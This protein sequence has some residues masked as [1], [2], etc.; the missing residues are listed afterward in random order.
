MASEDPPRASTADSGRCPICRAPTEK[1]YRP[2]CSGRCRDVDLLRW[3]RGAYA[4]PG[5]QA[6]ADEDGEDASVKRASYLR[7]DEDEEA[8]E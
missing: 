7:K 1:D 8:T 3:L 5:G 6:D 4:I 2:F